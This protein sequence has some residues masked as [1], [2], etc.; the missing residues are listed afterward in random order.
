M[1]ASICASRSSLSSNGSA[2]LAA[3]FAG[4]A[5]RTRSSRPSGDERGPFRAWAPPCSGKRCADE[6]GCACKRP[7]GGPD[8]GPWLLI[9]APAG[10]AH[11][12]AAPSAQCKC[13]C[14]AVGVICDM[15][16]I[17]PPGRSAVAAASSA[18]SGI[19]GS[20][21]W[22]PASDPAWSPSRGCASGCACTVPLGDA[23]ALCRPGARPSKLCRLSITPSSSSSRSR[24]CLRRCCLGCPEA[25]RLLR[26]LPLRR[27][28]P[29]LLRLRAFVALRLRPERSVAASST[30]ASASVSRSTSL[31]APE[32]PA[33][34]RLSRSSGLHAR[35]AA[36]SSDAPSAC[37]CCCCCCR[38][39]A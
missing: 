31:P 4:V 23:G 6:G 9:C 37:C 20:A 21:R 14:R 36:R 26:P 29:P 18:C 13:A 24:T 10:R 15:V 1:S 38:S 35:R 33:L 8:A 30:A 19:D 34:P 39:G 16:A 25:P 7:P 32:P 2:F 27:P 5:P 12:S 17:G 28:A 3:S 22:R 11:W